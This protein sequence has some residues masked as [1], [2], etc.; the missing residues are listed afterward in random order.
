MYIEELIQFAVGSGPWLFKHNN[1]IS[2]HDGTILSSLAEQIAFNANQLTEK[3]GHLALRVLNKHR[4]EL[5]LT[6]PLIDSILDQPKWKHPFRVISQQKRI[7]IIK[8][9]VEGNTGNVIALEFPYNETLVE[10]LR[11]RN[12]EVHQ[13]HKGTWDGNVKKWIFNI[14]ETT[15]EWIGTTFLAQ[16]FHASEEFIEL[17]R[18]VSEV[19]LDMEHHLPMLVHTSTGFEL[20]NCHKKIPQPKTTNLVEALFWAREY[21]VTTW[22]DTIDSKIKT[23][24]NPVTRTIL[25][26]ASSKH[27][28]V[29]S[30]MYPVDSF[31]DLLTYGGPALVVVP[32]GSELTMVKNW[33]EFA[34][35]LGIETKDMSVM[36]RLPNEQSDFNQFVKDN[37]LN[38]PITDTTRIVFVSTKITK[39]LIKSGVKFNTVINLGYYNYMHFTMSTVVDNA[40]N[41]VYYSTKAPTIQ[42]RWQPH[43]L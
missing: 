14:T 20:K 1:I 38:G 28:W 35:R 43:E 17:Y 11:K 31:T 27:P 12:S 36:F 15:I 2:G 39:P 8:T 16:E 5:R 22:D 34:Y 40:R 18:S 3:Q 6:V 21:G 23:E 10:L 33:M 19:F 41:L 37:E 4:S 42:K 32:G 24:I 25:S 9:P 7:L 13:L 30:S 29:D 26:L